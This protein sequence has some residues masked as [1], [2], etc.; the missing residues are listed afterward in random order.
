[1]PFVA[2]FFSSWDAIRVERFIWA[3]ELY[4]DCEGFS[5]EYQLLAIQAYL[6]ERA[7]ERVEYRRLRGGL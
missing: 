3:H 2:K 1:M 7:R 6:R 4:E 5:V